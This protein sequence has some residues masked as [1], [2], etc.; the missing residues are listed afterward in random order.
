MNTVAKLKVCMDPGEHDQCAESCCQS[1][2][3][4]ESMIT[5]SAYL[6]K[7]HR[8]GLKCPVG[9]TEGHFPCPLPKDGAQKFKLNLR[10]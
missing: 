2:L 3:A 7:K 8:V 4:L 9:W 1:L 6:Y 10:L 5:E